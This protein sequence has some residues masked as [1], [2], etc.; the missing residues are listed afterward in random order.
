MDLVTETF[1]V[2]SQDRTEIRVVT[3]RVADAVAETGAENGIVLVDTGHTTA[4][5]MTNEAEERLLRDIPEK[6]LDLV[7]PEEWYF[8]DQHHVDTDTQRNAWG[9][10]VSAMVRGPV[11]I[12]LEGGDLR[13]GTHEDVMVFEFD[14]PRE[15]TIDVTVLS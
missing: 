8:H 11:T 5:V 13:T 6:F 9:H 10:I 1:I 7:S 3:D 12:V 2:E 4:A 15:R 14:G